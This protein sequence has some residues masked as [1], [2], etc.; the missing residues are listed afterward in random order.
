M[1]VIL[2][3]GVIAICAYIGY[4]I[5]KTY[6][7]RKKFFFCFSSFLNQVRREINFNSRKLEE[8]LCSCNIN[9]K[10]FNIMV[11]NYRKLLLA[12]ESINEKTLFDDTLILS[13]QE[14]DCILDFFKSLGKLDV[15]NQVNT[16]DNFNKIVQDYYTTAKEESSKYST[17]YIKLGIIVGAFIALIII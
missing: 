2:C 16:I 1:K 5:S 12:G 15:Y 7:V 8:L 11:L 17:L 9:S 13:Q 3:I 14:K 6:I 4:S 10:E